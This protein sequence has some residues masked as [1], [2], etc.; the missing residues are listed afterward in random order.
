MNEYPD[1]HL[2]E[3][4]NEP[5][6]KSQRKREMLELQDLGRTL[7]ELRPDQLS[8]I[9][10]DDSL[11]QALHEL[12]AIR[13]H[14]AH[15]RQLQYVGKLMRSIETGPIRQALAGV[16][17]GNVENTR[18]LHLA[19]K[20]RERLI[21]EGDAAVTDFMALFPAAEAQHLRNLVRNARRDLD[22]QKNRGNGRKL[23]RYIRELVDD[24]R[25]SY[26]EN[27]D[28]GEEE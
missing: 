21:G 25:T 23:F 17:T 26:E 14:E 10:M 24:A 22:Q 28:T 9:P 1:T 2:P 20:W 3:P 15:R 7:S 27:G 11:R 18:R 16:Q 8:S 13:S 4:D 6:S 12:K 5:K 19:E